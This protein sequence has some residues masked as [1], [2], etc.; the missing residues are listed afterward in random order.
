MLSCTIAQ[1]SNDYTTCVPLLQAAE[2]QLHALSSGCGSPYSTRDCAASAPC[3]TGAGTPAGV[4][5]RTPDSG[6][7]DA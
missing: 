7:D 5:S 3:D 1:L 2:D 6:S 4:P